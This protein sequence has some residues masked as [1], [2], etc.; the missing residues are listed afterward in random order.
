MF[1]GSAHLAEGISQ[2]RV[3]MRFCPDVVLAVFVLLCAVP[4]R[5]LGGGILHVFPPT[6]GRETYAVARPAVLLSRALVT[7]SESKLEYKLNQTFYNDNEFPLEGVF[8]LPLESAEALHDIEVKSDG[9]SCPYTIVSSDDLFPMLK[10]LTRS[11]KDPSLLGLTGRDVLM[12]RPVSIGV[13]EQ[14]SFRIH[15]ARSVAVPRDQFTLVLPLD[16]ERY[17]LG[18]VGK[19]EVRVRFKMSR[20]L[21]SVFSPS[22]HLTVFRESPNRCLVTARSTDK[23]TRDDFRLLA[24]FSGEDLDVRIL[25]HRLPGRPGTFMALIEPPLVPLESRDPRKDMVVILDSSGSMDGKSYEIAKT[26]VI[27][28]LERLGVGDRF[29]VIT[30]GTRPERM[31]E[32]LVPATRENIAEA[33]RFV[34][35]AR[36]QGGTDLYNGLVNA[37]EYFTTKD[38][39]S[40]IMLISD[41]RCTVGMTKPET[42][43][44]HVRRYNRA[45]ARIFVLAVGRRADMAILDRLA[46]SSKG[47]SL[48]L[49]GTEDLDAAI[50][51]FLAGVS[52]PIV[53]DLSLAFQDISPYELVPS[54]LPD[55]LG[56]KGIVILGRY[57]EEHEAF[58]RIRIRGRVG[59][60]YFSKT[61]TVKFPVSQRDHHYI[62]GIWA[63][64]RVAQLLDRIRIEGS[65]KDLARRVRSLAE[66]FGLAIPRLPTLVQAS[67]LP[68]TAAADPGKLLWHYKQSFT[69]SDVTADGYQRV[70]G[71]TFRF[72]AGGW[73]DSAYRAAMPTRTVEFLH[74][75]YFSLLKTKPFLGRF[76][77]LGPN[78]TVVD[79][80]R[81]IHVRPSR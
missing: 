68:T 38:R 54:P 33:V 37:L 21:R 69:I 24:T 30:I 70:A 20:P 67:R 23:R 17:A 27:A 64:R 72:Q 52:P 63:M 3:T 28:A 2:E 5:C 62:P 58:P 55:Q 61:R 35:A 77:A 46:V 15:Y 4:P 45:R 31:S 8:F 10:Q 78:V 59:G 11:M 56:S 36:N 49:E 74:E 32:G 48:H 81:A 75:D 65:Q 76:L 53:S 50:N 6:Y 43:L 19:L 44:E 12:V 34:N 1:G 29:G 16:G 39:P 25:S 80:A 42:L 22:H 51:G 41:G 13:R 40:V 66:E 73:V 60:R 57:N 14:K 7:V 47:S 71:K 18:P 79:H 9:I 26:A